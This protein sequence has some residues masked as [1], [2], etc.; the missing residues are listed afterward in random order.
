M[1]AKQALRLKIEELSEE[2]AEEL[3]HQ[4]DWD[5]SP[6]ETLT[7]DEIQEMLEGEAEIARGEGVLLED[8]LKRLDL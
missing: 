2:E 1:T 6:T 7:P 8:L 3:L 5:S 4:L